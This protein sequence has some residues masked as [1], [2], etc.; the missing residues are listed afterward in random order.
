MT[1]ATGPRERGV[2]AKLPGYQHCSLCAA[3]LGGTRFQ[4]SQFIVAVILGA[5]KLNH[6]PRLTFRI[7]PLAVSSGDG[8]PDN[9]R[10]DLPN[11]SFSEQT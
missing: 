7:A 5:G 1:E 11:A 4:P 9:G 10:P 3:P 8:C 6:S 2:T